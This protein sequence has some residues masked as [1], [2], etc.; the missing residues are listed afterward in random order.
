[1]HPGELA[2][3]QAR[4]AVPGPVTALLLER[5]LQVLEDLLLYVPEP[6]LEAVRALDD[7]HEP[8]VALHQPDGG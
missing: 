4:R 3:H 6:G 2:G 5:P 1:M 8:R 7:P